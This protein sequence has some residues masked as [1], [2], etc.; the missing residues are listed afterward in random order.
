M[1]MMD[2]IVRLLGPAIAVL[3]FGVI[4]LSLYKLR[5]FVISSYYRRHP[6]RP[7]FLSYDEEPSFAD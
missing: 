2:T 1:T 5:Q 3:L 6:E 7:P 4:L